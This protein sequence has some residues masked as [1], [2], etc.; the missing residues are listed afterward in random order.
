VNLAHYIGLISRSQS[1]LADAFR[2]VARE[3]A[4]EAAIHFTAGQLA[5]Q[6]VQHVSQLERFVDQYGEDLPEEPERLHSD[7]FQ[8]SRQGPLGM[9]RDLHDLYL[10]A[11]EVDIAWTVVAQAAQGARDPELL[12]VTSD[13]EKETAT[14]LKWLRS[15]MKEAAPQVL[16]VAD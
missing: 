7:L 14:Q 5:D 6:C 2:E 4:A 3:H 1:L 12:A 15:Q 10:M 8:G 13:C 11:A 9:L 16:V